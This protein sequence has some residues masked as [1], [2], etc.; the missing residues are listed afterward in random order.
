MEKERSQRSKE[1]EEVNVCGNVFNY[2]DTHTSTE[3]LWDTN[4]S[5]STPTNGAIVLWVL[6]DST[7][8]NSSKFSAKIQAHLLKW[9]IQTYLLKNPTVEK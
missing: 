8:S 4:R 1:Q 5:T 7:D 6:E 3:V 9:T 2:A